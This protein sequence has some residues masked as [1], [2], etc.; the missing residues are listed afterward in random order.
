M[1]ESILVSDDQFV[2]ILKKMPANGIRDIILKFITKE[3]DVKTNYNGIG[4]SDKNDEISF[5]PDNQFQRL[6]SNGEDVWAKN[7]SKSKIGRMAR[8]LLADNKI[9]VSDSNIEEFVNLFKSTWDKAHSTTRKVDI[10]KGDAILHWYNKDNYL[11]GLGTLGNSCMRH[12][13]VNKFMKIYANNPDKISMVILT[14][15]DKLLARALLW[16]L[17][18]SEK[19]HKFF[20]DRIYTRNDSDSSFIHTW[21][22]ENIVKKESELGSYSQGSNNRM[23]CKLQK[24]LFGE[25][26]YA[27]TFKFLYKKVGN[28]GKV[29]GD[30]MVSNERMDEEK[31]EY[32]ISEMQETDGNE[33][34]YT[35]R[36]S[37]F[38]D[39][40]IL[41]EDAAW[42]DSI[43]SW[44]KKEDVKYC[45]FTN[46]YFLE[47]ESV[48]SKSMNDWI[49]KQSSIDHPKFG[50]I[51]RQSVVRVI[52]KYIGEQ[53]SPF[54]IA[55]EMR[56]MGDDIEKYFEVEELLSKRD[57][58][59]QE[60]F[61]PRVNITYDYRLF[62]KNLE[63]IDIHR[64][65]YP[66]FLCVEVFGIVDNVSR[67][68]LS[69][70]PYVRNRGSNSISEI[71]AIFYN[72]KIDKAVSGYV[73]YT[74]YI[75]N[76]EDDFY[77][78]YQDDKD[79][80]T[81]DEEIKRMHSMFIESIHEYRLS[82]E[83]YYKSK[84]T[85]LKETRNHN[86]PV[87]E[88]LFNA[89]KISMDRALKNVDILSKLDDY[90]TPGNIRSLMVKLQY[91]FFIFY[92]MRN[93]N[94]RSAEV[95]LEYFIKSRYPDISE[96][97]NKYDIYSNTRMIFM[98]EVRHYTHS[99]FNSAISDIKDELKLSMGRSDL[100]DIMVSLS[101][102]ENIYKLCEEFI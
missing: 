2:R 68:V 30:G 18:E 21:V 102:A 25:Y 24:V 71:D 7:K 88:I 100:I 69:R 63:V 44:M 78:K 95:D 8:Q 85:F 89:A 11:D 60:Y 50:I 57:E 32:V 39:I 62:N 79:N 65:K 82:S 1:C 96:E 6:L 94:S 98:N 66:D 70:V 48:Y 17:D 77:I 76:L 35:H 101:T 99:E 73:Y 10:V 31:K 52:S 16:K 14:E 33:N 29:I 92:I 53:T 58:D 64:H 72:I 81:S 5:I 42:I 61:R 19:D 93:D 4:I 27:D 34:I 56:D 23:V 49:N 54:G 91:P 75:S 12:P 80:F 45:K 59:E 67:D 40:Y 84:H 97:S 37:Q 51:L 83:S 3:E 20:L 74:D 22:L 43:D 28:N 36:H 38:S 13:S 9:I 90:R 15:S 46:E 86:M 87:D 41:R 26:P 55:K 47:E